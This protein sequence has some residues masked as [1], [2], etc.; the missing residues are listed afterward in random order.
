MQLI[1][2]LIK[3]HINKMS[4]ALLISCGDVNGNDSLIFELSGKI[5]KLQHALGCSTPG[6]N[7]EKFTQFCDQFQSCLT[8]EINA[9]HR[10]CHR[11]NVV[12]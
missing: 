10:R 9:Q 7:S 11:S 3:C 5:F 2:A 6:Q 4:C 1:E 8:P 12:T